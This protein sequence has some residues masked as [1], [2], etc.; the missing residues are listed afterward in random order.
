MILSHTVLKMSVAQVLTRSRYLKPLSLGLGIFLLGGQ[1]AFAVRDPGRQLV[2]TQQVSD[3]EP[4]PAKEFS[5]LPKDVQADEVVSY[6]VKG[7]STATVKQKLVELKA[8]CRKGKLVDAKGREIR[9]FR[10]P[11]WGNPPEDYLD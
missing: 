11:C 3:D 6:N 4:A 9:F 8:R 1:L 5:C 10:T 2:F 7:K